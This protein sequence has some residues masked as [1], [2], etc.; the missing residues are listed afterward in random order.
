MADTGNPWFIP[1]A[2]PSDLVRDW[3][4]LSS[5]VGT[6]VAGGLS[7]VPIQQV[8]QTVKNDTFTT[9]SATFVDITGMS[10]TITPAAN[11]NKV[12]IVATMVNARGGVGSTNVRINLLRNSTNIAQPA[13]GTSAAT[14]NAIFNTAAEN[15][16]A[17]I[18]FLDS[19]A[20]TSAVTYKLQVAVGA[21]TFNFNLRDSNTDNSSISTITAFEVAA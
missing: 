15:Y 20:T 10:V 19:P 18:V 9:S 2:E 7:T 12:L 16:P 14:L 11:T 8:V 6:A 5:A 3:P 17:T 13:S 4:A 1:F 21:N